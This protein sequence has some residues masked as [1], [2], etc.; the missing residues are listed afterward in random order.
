MTLHE[1]LV[2]AGPVVLYAYVLCNKF[3]RSC[4]SSNASNF[5]DEDGELGGCGSLITS[6]RAR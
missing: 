4:R 3:Y 1:M 6:L 2:S 5:M